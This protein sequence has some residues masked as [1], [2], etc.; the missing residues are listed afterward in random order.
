MRC[1]RHSVAA[2]IAYCV[3]AVKASELV[4]ISS[5]TLTVLANFV[6]GTGAAVD[7]VISASLVTL[8]LMGRTGFNQRCDH[9]LNSD[10]K[11]PIDVSISTDKLVVR[12]VV[13]TVNTGLWTALFGLL[14]VILLVTLPRADIVYGITNFPISSLY[15]NTMIATLNVRTYVRATSDNGLSQLSSLRVASGHPSSGHSRTKVD[16]PMTSVKTGSS[17]TQTNNESVLDLTHPEMFPK[18]KG[19]IV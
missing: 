10:H 13:I 15:F 16:V 2:S 12:L 9:L 3:L 19:S 14:S 1:L 4:H 11:V 8:L 5:E 18:M 17:R 7:I 6:N